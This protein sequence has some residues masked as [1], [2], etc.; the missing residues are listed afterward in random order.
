METR[1]VVERLVE[2]KG[3]LAGKEEGSIFWRRKILLV[4]TKNVSS[5]EKRTQ[6]R[7]SL[8]RRQGR[9][10]VGRRKEK[11]RCRNDREKIS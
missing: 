6:K 4:R 11:G 8:F 9:C 5:A 1:R 10:F 2:F 3:M 7:K